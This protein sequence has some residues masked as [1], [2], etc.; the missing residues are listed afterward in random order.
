[1]IV[2]KTLP[3][4]LLCLSALLLFLTSCS[5]NKPIVNALDERDANEIIVFLSSK[6][7]QASKVP[8][9]QSDGG[10]GGNKMIL[11]NISVPPDQ[12]IEAMNYLN[13]EGLPRR[14]AENL[15]EIFSNSSLVPS[16]MQEQ[17]R[18][19]AGLEQQIA[20]T[21]R[22][23][24][25]VLDANVIISFPEKDPLDPSKNLTPITASVYVKHNGVLD[26]PN[27]H[28]ISKI[29][30][31]VAA[32]VPGLSYDNVTVVGN[33]AR[34]GELPN[35]WLEAMQKQQDQLVDVWSMTI[36]KT[37]LPRFRL[38]FFSFVIL[39]V[40]L[41]LIVAWLIWKILPLLKEQGIGQLL[42]FKHFNTHAPLAEPDKKAESK[43]DEDESKN[44][45]VT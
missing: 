24:D 12:A 30:K 31:L 13:Q 21:I 16:A 2:N 29:R 22:K 23:I 8:S 45:D 14:H 15:L 9:A 36:A 17:I 27:S 44:S 3:P 5:S 42:S 26:D 7:I 37:S 38:I 43:S 19:R 41:A 10:G 1:M 34:I 32:S 25:G 20:N 35:P 18:Y 33:R 6:G 28:L 11:W 39:L 40:L 4:L